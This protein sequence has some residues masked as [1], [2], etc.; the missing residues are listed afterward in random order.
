MLNV[1]QIENATDHRNKK[2]IK[3]IKFYATDLEIQR[4]ACLVETPDAGNRYKNKKVKSFECPSL[5]K[6]DCPDEATKSFAIQ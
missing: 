3:K 2:S 6:L 5:A 1:P 4:A